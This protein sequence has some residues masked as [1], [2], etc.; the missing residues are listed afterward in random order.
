MKLRIVIGIAVVGLIACSVYFF[1]TRSGGIK[2]NQDQKLPAQSPRGIRTI[3]KAEQPAE[4][5]THGM[6]SE[7][8]RTETKDELIARCKEL[9][10][11]NARGGIFVS[12]YLDAIKQLAD[13]DPEAALGLFESEARERGQVAF[14]GFANTVEI[15]GKRDPM[16]LKL[17]LE[18]DL[19]K[20]L[21]PDM[22]DSFF[23]IGLKSL[24][25]VSPKLAFELIDSSSLEGAQ[26]E[27]V[28]R[29]MLLGV[30]SADLSLALNEVD[31]LSPTHASEVLASIAK[32]AVGIDRA[33]A[34]KIAE[35]IKDDGLKMRTLG[36][37]YSRWFREDAPTA[38]QALLS[39][40]KDQR[41][42]LLTNLS[43]E[44]V[45]DTLVTRMAEYD[46]KLLL[47]LIHEVEITSDSTRFLKVAVS[48]MAGTQPNEVYQEIAKFEDPELRLVLYSNFYQEMVW[49]GADTAG[50]LLSKETDPKV[51]EV[52]IQKLAPA[53]GRL[54]MEDTIHWVESLPP[55]ARSTALAEAMSGLV[56]SDT[57]AVADYLTSETA[58]KIDLP[59][60]TLGDIYTHTG[61][62]MAREKT[63]EL[64]EWMAKV[65]EQHR[66]MAMQGVAMEMIDQ[67]PELFTEYLNHI[68]K[69]QAWIRGAEIMIMFLEETDTH[70]AN[71]WKQ[72]IKD[73]GK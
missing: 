2:E 22:I 53:I 49:S 41:T 43:P 71:Q 38:G 10:R 39:L 64:Q 50:L 61:E 30:A 44:G 19:S 54:G 17:W 32:D 51:R 59:D 60:E 62:F 26:R 7:E 72:A 66:A 21:P 28:V 24:G 5:A 12:L 36:E 68:P 27:R 58:H 11:G 48:K 31:K 20:V 67:D 52:A 23:G 45:E 55:D 40:D 33:Q 6:E 35:S 18:Q 8:I 3:T 37:V 42:V 13:M 63:S 70:G 46:P 65:P 25:S 9:A 57:R 69:D 14:L 29:L 34:A 15:I 16:K 4:S 47:S 1:T 73:A 56:Q